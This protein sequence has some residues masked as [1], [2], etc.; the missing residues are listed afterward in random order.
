MATTATVHPTVG[1]RWKPRVWV[2]W[3]HRWATLTLGVLLLVVTTSGALAVF[4]YELNRLSFPQFYRTT[5][6]T[7]PV[8][9]NS[10]YA[11]VVQALANEPDMQQVYIADTITRPGDVYQFFLREADGHRVG[12]AFVDPATG[13]Y[14]GHYDSDTT[15]WSWLATLHYSLF[16]DE[17]TFTYPEWVPEWAK[18]WFGETLAELLL[19]HVALL[20]FIL[21]LTGAYLWWPGI[22]KFAYGF[23]VRPK[24]S[25]MAWHYDWHKVIGFASLPFL[26]MWALTG[27]N[28]Y[29]PFSDWIGAGWYTVTLSEAPPDW[30]EVASTPSGSPM[31]SLERAGQIARET[32]PD[33]T[34][35]SIA[36]PHEPDG[37]V[38]IWMTQGIDPYGYAEWPGWINLSLDAYSGAVLDNNLDRSQSLAANF[39]NNW[40]YPLHTG[41]FVPWQARIVWAVFGLIPLF[42]AFTGVMQWW[43]KRSKRKA[44]AE[45]RMEMATSVGD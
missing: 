23:R 20:L 43:L 38:S 3:L 2:Q 12:S 28:F 24:A 5:M 40:F 21:V 11:T 7:S 42:L 10:A 13:A 26:L 31:I 44:R 6:T 27:L 4:N 9:L 19:K 8:S 15:V 1:L 25:G 37:T 16:A 41:S 30:P 34:I 35:I 32:V 17:V 33:A 22:K 45:R 18:T 29:A 36:L 39:Y 14:L